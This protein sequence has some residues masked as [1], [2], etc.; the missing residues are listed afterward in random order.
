MRRGILSIGFARSAATLRWPMPTV[1]AVWLAASAALIAGVMV[2][3]PV[4]L[5]PAVAA[6]APAPGRVPAAS[7]IGAAGADVDDFSFDSF[8]AEYRLGVDAEGRSTLTTVE[9]LVAR[10]PEFDQNRGIRRALVT[11]YD[12]HPTDLEV[13]SVTDAAGTPREYERATEGDSN[14]ILMLTIRGEQFVHGVQTYVITYEQ[15]NVTLATGSAD[16]FYWDTNGTGWPQPFGVVSA[17]VTLEDGLVD[18]LNGDSACYY[19]AEGATN[20]CELRR[21]STVFEVEQRDLGAHEN[22]TVAIGFEPGTFVPR[23]DRYFASWLSWVQL[24]S[25]AAALGA[26]AWALVLRAT[27][28]RD[29]DGRPVI[30]A[31]YLPP[32]GYDLL[33][34]AEVIGRRG[35]AVA[36]Q[37][38]DLAVR[39]N[40]RVLAEDRPLGRDRFS[41]QLVSTE[42]LSGQPL[43]LVQAFFGP[44]ASPGAVRRIGDTSDRKAGRAVYGLLQKQPARARRAG[45]RRRVPLQRVILP[46]VIAL[47]AAVAGMLVA[48]LL[49][50]DARGGAL[51]LLLML[52]I[53]AAVV[54]SAVCVFRRPLTAQGAEL[55][56]HLRGMELYIRVAEQERLRVLQSPQGAERVP[57]DPND[58]EQMLRLNERMLPY[59]VLFGLER[60]W[61]AELARYTDTD[62]DWYHGSTP[63]SA[64]AFASGIAGMSAASSSSYS[65]SS[66]SGGSSGGGSSGGGGGGGGGGG[67]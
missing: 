14:E 10:F 24:L 26:A 23:D 46:F 30:V 17:R 39:R 63:F 53:V 3:A 49:T 12:G 61:A 62:P 28:T 19:G 48:V 2:V 27:R 45:L 6:G 9:T 66:S 21:S 18:R 38:I 58:R 60:E 65:G 57:V 36:A 29:A 11:R 16:E 54:V 42:Q 33:A 56:D 47:F 55:R 50:E 20:R 43:E 5:S 15:H 7:V 4:A 1:R 35:R 34:S 25:L 31:E 59:A 32:R 41:I 64:A 40:L 37:L 44:A 67:A 22:V 51:P 8:A 52:P 13:V